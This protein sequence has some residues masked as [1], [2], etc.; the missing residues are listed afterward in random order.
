MKWNIKFFNE[1]IMILKKKSTSLL[2]F[3]AFA[4]IFGGI[5]LLDGIPAVKAAYEG[6]KTRSYQ[7]VQAHLLEVGMESHGQ[8][9]R[10]SG[11]FALKGRYYYEVGGKTY[12]SSRIGLLPD[13]YNRGEEWNE[14]WHAQLSNAY[15]NEKPVIAWVNPEKPREA[16]I[17]R[18]FTQWHFI[19]VGMLFSA[20]GLAALWAF[21]KVLIS[22]VSSPYN[23]F[24]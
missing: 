2:C 19:L 7:P 24:K 21:I 5:G 10:N 23:I 20:I 6:W 22:P 14:R 9:K 12:E 15:E 3:G 16:V 4:L 18:E 11:F 17:D 8:R 13:S 1:H